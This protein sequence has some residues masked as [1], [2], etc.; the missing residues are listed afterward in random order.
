[1]LEMLFKETYPSWFYSINQ[2]ATTM[3]ERW[4]SYT[5]EDGF[6]KGGMNSF[7]HYAYGTI[8]QWIYERIAGIKPIK[9]GYKQILIAPIPGP[10]TS[11]QARYNSPYGEVSSAWKKEDGLF[12]LKVNVPPNTTAKIIIPGDIDEGLTLN[13]KPFTDHADVKL[14]GKSEDSF[15][16]EAQP[17]SWNFEVSHK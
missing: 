7:N 12:E 9:A 8:G 6:N 14:I 13:G 15:E 1:M 17:G 3:W 2:G 11:A 5:H 10:L 16:L 4:N